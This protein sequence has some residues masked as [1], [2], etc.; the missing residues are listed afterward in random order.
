MKLLLVLMLAFLISCAGAPTP[1]GT[2]SVPPSDVN[3][4]LGIGIGI[5]VAR[6]ALPAAQA[7]LDSDPAISVATRAQID[8]GFRAS[9]D[10]LPLAQ[11]ALNT[12]AHAP[13]NTAALCQVHFYLEQALTGALQ[14][15]VI[16]RDAG[17]IVDPMVAS[18]IGGIASA[19]DMLLSSSCAASSAPPMARRISAQERVRAALV[20]R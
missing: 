15:I 1:G 20:S 12:F 19:A 9:L 6:A 3:W 11:T 18:A 17:V 10:A 16:A 13:S 8:A 4:T 5:S 2:V 14:A 7:A